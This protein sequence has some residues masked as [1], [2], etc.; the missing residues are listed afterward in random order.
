LFPSFRGIRGRPF[1]LCSVLDSGL[2]VVSL[3]GVVPPR[4]SIFFRFEYAEM[5]FL[6]TVCSRLVAG[7]GFFA[8]PAALQRSGL[9]KG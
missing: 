3:D 4:S 5:A 1:G 6:L 9:A 8:S 2:L 7:R